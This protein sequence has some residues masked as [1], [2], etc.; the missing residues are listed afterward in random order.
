MKKSLKQITGALS[1]EPALKSIEV[2][3]FLKGEECFH[4]RSKKS[5]SQD[6][7]S[8][9]RNNILDLAEEKN[10]LISSRVLGYGA[11]PVKNTP[12]KVA[13]GPFYLEDALSEEELRN[14]FILMNM[15][16][17]MFEVTQRFLHEQPSLPFDEFKKLISRIDQELNG[18]PGK[19]DIFFMQTANFSASLSSFYREEIEKSEFSG[20]VSQE[21]KNYQDE[22]KVMEAV[23]NGSAGL[24]YGLLS[25]PEFFPL[26]GK[27]LEQVRNEAVYFLSL[28]LHA[29]MQGGLD[30][31][32]F[33]IIRDMYFKKVLEKKEP[34]QIRAVLF[35]LIKELTQ[36]VSTFAFYLTDN[37]A[38]NRAINYIQT[39]IKEKLNAEIISHDL[40]LTPGYI[41]SCFKKRTNMS[42][43]DYINHQ[44][45]DEA[46]R[47]LAYT[48]K[49]LADIS[50]YFS[51]SSQSYF[52][53]IFKKQTG[54]T[55]KEYQAKN[56]RLN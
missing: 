9:V 53:R 17:A 56:V 15:N 51:F 4:L 41:S 8:Y 10:C 43:P 47:L 49:S 42:L 25:N 35:D 13:F 21:E 31:S 44:K 28:A 46:K 7:L 11:I 32:T 18:E 30:A 1:K 14:L 45:I 38:I 16:T 39:H 37:P 29:A 6:L 19:C 20:D 23:K 33:A 3:I 40:H 22:L 27:E 12:Y 34:K 24:V 36:R 26:E 54:L 48:D 52:Q 50:N 55:P 5:G 2:V